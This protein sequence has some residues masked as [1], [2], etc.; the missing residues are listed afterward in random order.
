M[1]DRAVAERSCGA[2]ADVAEASAPARVVEVVVG[3]ADAVDGAPVEGVGS[4]VEGGAWADAELVALGV[5][6][7]NPGD[8]VALADVNPPSTQLLEPLDLGGDVVDAQVEVDAR[9]A[10]LGLRYA[11]Q[12]HRR[13]RPFGRQQQAVL[14][15]APDDAVAER[16]RPERGQRL[17]IGA[18]D[19][20]VDI[21]L[22]LLSHPLSLASPTEGGSLGYA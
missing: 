15:A 9:L 3:Q 2:F 1:G 8:V 22:Q 20:D 19:D 17:G 12:D 16:L 7:R 11:L 6:H 21:R 4:D 14:L 5:G 13:I 18:V 10:L